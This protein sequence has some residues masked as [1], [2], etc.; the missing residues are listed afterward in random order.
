MLL[1]RLLQVTEEHCTDRLSCLQ[2]DN[3]VQPHIPRQHL[4]HWTALLIKMWTTICKEFNFP[5]MQKSFWHA[6][7]HNWLCWTKYWPIYSKT[8]PLFYFD[9]WTKPTTTDQRNFIPHTH[10]HTHTQ[11]QS[12]QSKRGQKKISQP[13]AWSRVL[14][15]LVNSSKTVWGN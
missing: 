15:G 2:P 7:K 8:T 4:K 12:Q 11:C 9:S 6:C 1:W 5:T 13:K 14:V 10:I 3:P